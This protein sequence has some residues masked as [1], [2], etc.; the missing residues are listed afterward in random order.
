VKYTLARHNLSKLAGDTF[1]TKV[2]SP[3]DWD[4]YPPLNHLVV[5]WGAV[6]L[7]DSVVQ[8]TANVH[9]V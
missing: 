9:D 7:P 8:I 5:V 6:H 2:V 3:L 1:I 4:Q